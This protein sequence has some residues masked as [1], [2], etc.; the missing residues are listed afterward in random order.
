MASLELAVLSPSKSVHNRQLFSECRYFLVGYAQKSQQR[1]TENKRWVEVK[2]YSRLN[3]DVRVITSYANS[4]YDAFIDDC[5]GH[6]TLNMHLADS[7]RLA[8]I[9]STASL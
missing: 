7:L 8:L 9:A 3:N 6:Y 1:V 2:G 4:A 5:H